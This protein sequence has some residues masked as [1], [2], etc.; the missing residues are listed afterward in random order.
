MKIGTLTTGAASVDVFTL[1]YLPAYIY[2]IAATQLTSLK[3]TVAGDGVICDLDA[4]GLNAVSGVR[5]YGA[6]TNSYMIPLANGFVPNKVVEITTV[7]SAAQTPDLF[8]FSLQKGSAYIVNRQSKC[9]AS[10]GST[11][12]DFALLA[13]KSPTTTDD[14]SIGFADGHVQKFVSTELLGWWTLYSN[15]VDSYAVDNVDG[16]ID[17][18]TLIPST[19]R[20]VYQTLYAPIGQIV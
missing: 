3:V 8:G 10:S 12:R 18:V 16:M 4:D 19:D 11:F 20:I 15:E 14:I 9:L 2:F 1:N 17:Y 6:V 7:N 5:R 13:L